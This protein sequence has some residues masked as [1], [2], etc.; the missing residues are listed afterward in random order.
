MVYKESIYLGQYSIP[1]TTIL[2]G[3]KNE[4]NLRINRPLVVQNYRVVQDEI[5]FMEKSKFN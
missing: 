2:N 5:I 1:L 4:G 3:S